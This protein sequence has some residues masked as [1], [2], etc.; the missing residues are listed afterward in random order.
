MQDSK[1]MELKLAFEDCAVALQKYV[2]CSLVAYDA[3]A[4]DLKYHQEFWDMV[5]VQR[6]PEITTET[7]TY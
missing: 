7:K 6:V 4:G 2:I 3:M 5:I 1:D